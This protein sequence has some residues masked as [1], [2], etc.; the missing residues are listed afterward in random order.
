MA[1]DAETG[2]MVMQMDEGLDTG[3]VLMAERVAIG[4]K[5]AGELTERT[6]A[7]GRRPDGAGAGRAGAGRDQRPSPRPS[8]A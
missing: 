8:A 5:T 6:V 7:A 2:V 4:R 1:G 3:P